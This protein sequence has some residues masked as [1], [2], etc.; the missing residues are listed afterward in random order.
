L[1]F[2]DE[3]SFRQDSTLHATWSRVGCPPEVPVTGQRKSVKI[4]GAIELCKARFHYRQD[5]VFNASTYFAF[6]E[7][8][9]RSYRR[10]GAV[11]IQD[12]ATYHKDGDVWAWFDANR[13]W[14]EVHQLPPYSPEL[15]PTERL[16]RYTRQTGTHNRYFPDE[17][18]LT[19]TLSRVFGEMQT[20]PELIRPHLQSFL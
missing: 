13:R 8:L 11:L 5:T 9:A 19:G 3:A 12:N 17:K 14:L 16:W 20:Y 1:I 4:F 15:N 10:Q 2:T 6:L 7:Q 18:E